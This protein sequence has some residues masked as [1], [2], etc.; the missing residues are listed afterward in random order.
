MNTEMAGVF[1]FA[2][3]DLSPQVSAC[4]RRITQILDFGAMGKPHSEQLQDDWLKWEFAENVWLY[5]L[6]MPF[7]DRTVMLAWGETGSVIPTHNHPHRSEFVTVATGVVRVW[8]GG[9]VDPVEMTTKSPKL[10]IPKGANHVIEWV[11]D[12]L[13]FQQY[14]PSFEI[15]IDR[16]T[17]NVET[18]TG[19]PV[20]SLKAR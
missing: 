10:H 16:G 8:I 12:A 14:E 2:G 6:P 13:V 3:S 11:T 15:E 17:I 5:S 1:P 18:P 7:I 20:K 4:R 19:Q 9:A